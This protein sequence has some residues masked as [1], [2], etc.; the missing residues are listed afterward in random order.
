MLV[1]PRLGAGGLPAGPDAQRAE[2]RAGD[3][4]RDPGARRPARAASGSARTSA[5]TQLPANVSGQPGRLD[6]RRL[7]HGAEQGPAA[8]PRSSPTPTSRP[9]PRRDGS[10]PSTA[11]KLAETE[12]QR[13]GRRAAGADRRRRSRATAAARRAAGGLQGAAR[14][15]ADRRRPH[16]GRDVRRE[17]RRRSRPTRSNRGRCARWC[18]PRSS[19][20]C[21]GWRRVPRRLPRRFDP[22]RRGSRSADG[23]PGA[24]RRPGRTAAGQPTDRPQR[25]ARVRRRDLSRPAHQRPVPRPRP[26]AAGDPGDELAAR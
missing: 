7:G 23:R 22:D 5:S 21:S 17:V 6:R 3:P 4:D 14:P 15:A 18:S 8:P 13:Q 20:C 26:A 24:R 2:P 9:T 1:E 25:A 11:S 16:D 10:R 12:L 19:A